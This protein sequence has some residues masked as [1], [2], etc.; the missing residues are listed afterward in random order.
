MKKAKGVLENPSGIM[1][2][3]QVARRCDG[4]VDVVDSKSTAGN[5]VPVRVRPPVPK[6]DNPNHVFP[7]GD[8]FGFFVSIKGIL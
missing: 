6:V 7:I 5:S 2:N 4:M 3:D 8:G 1:Y